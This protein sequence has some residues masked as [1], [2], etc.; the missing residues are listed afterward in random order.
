[1][2]LV[3]ARGSVGDTSYLVARKYGG[4]R[5]DKLLTKLIALRIW[6]SAYG[7]P[8]RGDDVREEYT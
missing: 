5:H 1:V 3:G 7:V 6:A 4:A 2:V 8:Q